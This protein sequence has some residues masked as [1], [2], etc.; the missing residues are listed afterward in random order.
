VIC[1]ICG[2]NTTSIEFHHYFPVSTR[3]KSEEGVSLCP[4]CHRQI[5]LLFSNTELRNELNSLT[6]F[7]SN[8]I[9]IAWI[10]WV[11]DKPVETK[12]SV[13]KKKRKK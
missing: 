12:F 1:P 7:L 4:Q 10:N 5:H 6:K 9:I 2:R 8:A 11:K 13:A 3:R